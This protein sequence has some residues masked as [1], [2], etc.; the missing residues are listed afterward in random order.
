[1][2]KDT[3]AKTTIIKYVLSAQRLHTME[4]HIDIVDD[5]GKILKSVPR[6]YI[7]QNK[8]LHRTVHILIKDTKGNILLQKRSAEKDFAP[9]WWSS[10][11]G[12]HIKAG[13]TYEQAAA[14]ELEEELGITIPLTYKGEIYYEDGRHIKRFIGLCEATYEGKLHL[15]P[16]E[17]ADA[18][19]FDINQ[20]KKLIREG[21]LMQE[22]INL[23]I[24]HDYL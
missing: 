4:E 15:N 11:A 1:M 17:V 8:P 22:T 14:R 19:Y 3:C 10:S 5:N 23:L 18:K 6:S 16:E 21:R 9:L 13:E 7:Y 12:G 24:S 2:L 20:I